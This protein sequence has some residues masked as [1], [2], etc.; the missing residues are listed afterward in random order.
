MF[1]ALRTRSSFAI[2]SGMSSNMMSAAKP[3]CLMMPQTKFQFSAISAKVVNHDESDDMTAVPRISLEEFYSTVADFTISDE[4]AYEY[5]T[6]AA[7]LAMVSFKDEE[8]LMSFK[9][10]FQA[11]LAFIQ[12]LDEVDVSK[13]KVASESMRSHT[14]S[15]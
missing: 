15:G 2:K 8:E 10:D 6:F 7:K 5:M 4:D 9:G 11:A 3:A 12:K 1:N 13:S 14:Q